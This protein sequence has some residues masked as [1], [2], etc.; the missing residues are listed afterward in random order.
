MTCPKAKLA[1]LISGT[2]STMQNLV[3][4]IEQGDLPARI[5]LVIA[6]R[7]DAPGIAR[8]RAAGLRCEVLPRK[9]F[10]GVEAYSEAL[11]VCINAAG[12]DLVCMAG[13]LCFWQIP[14]QWMGRSLNIHPSL[15]PNFG[16]PGMHGLHV[17]QAVI[18]AGATRSG[19]T[20][21][22]AD[23][24][25]DHGPIILQRACPVYPDD[26]PETLAARVFAEEIIAY[27]EAIKKV[28]IDMNHPDAPQKPGN[29]CLP[30]QR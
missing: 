23:N 26:T 8:A 11:R 2:G 10:A 29:H 12:V 17:H 15:L 6:S 24:Q 4:A 25:Y 9:T 14:P 1:V 3:K 7:S 5:E 21:H 19:C 20:V 28:W 13:F 30:V 18:K 27:P 22:F 16:G